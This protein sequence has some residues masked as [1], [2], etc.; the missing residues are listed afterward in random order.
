M[1]FQHQRTSGAPV[2]RSSRLGRSA[3]PQPSVGKELR[4][5][6]LAS[7]L[8]V[9]KTATADP[10]EPRVPLEESGRQGARREVLFDR[11]DVA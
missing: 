9:D 3:D 4:G 7:P 10:N 5:G 2:G 8:Q 1:G 11:E 6:C